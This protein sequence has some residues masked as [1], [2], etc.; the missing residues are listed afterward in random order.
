MSGKYAAARI[1][2]SVEVW[3]DRKTA[4]AENRLPKMRREYLRMRAENSGFNSRYGIGRCPKVIGV[5]SHE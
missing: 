5:G 4:R 3:R 2:L 1:R